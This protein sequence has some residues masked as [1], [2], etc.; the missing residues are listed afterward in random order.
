M[1]LR[2]RRVWPGLL[3]AF[4]LATSPGLRLCQVKPLTPP[5]RPLTSY[6]FWLDEHRQI[7]RDSLPAQA[8]HT[9]VLKEA[10]RRWRS[11]KKTEKEKY[12]KAASV[13]KEAYLKDVQD[14]VEAGGIMPGA[15]PTKDPAIPKRPLNAYMLFVGDHRQEIKDSLPPNGN[16]LAEAGKRWRALDDTAREQY[17]ARAEQ[18]KAAHKKEMKEFLESGG[19]LPKSKRQARTRGKRATRKDPLQPKRPPTA[20]ML[21]L[22]ENREKIAAA[23]PPGHRGVTDVSK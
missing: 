4:A 2:G 23:L 11:L 17:Q 8:A 7:I 5:K 20:W 3:A 1:R 15:K 12:E 18:L 6:F 16:F 13:A 10:G 22:Q 9:E 21:W 19:V 14:F